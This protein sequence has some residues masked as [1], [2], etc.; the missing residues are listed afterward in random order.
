MIQGGSSGSAS[1]PEAVHYL[2]FHRF[3]NGAADA[4]I[5]ATLRPMRP[6]KVCQVAV[7]GAKD[8]EENDRSHDKRHQEKTVDA[9]KRGSPN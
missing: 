1:Q 6:E 4:S 3:Q 5:R 7:K 2:L 8:N 9:L